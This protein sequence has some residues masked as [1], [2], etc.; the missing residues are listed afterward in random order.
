MRFAAHAD[1]AI[2]WL[3]RAN[4]VAR[5][6]LHAIALSLAS[7]RNDVL[8]FSRDKIYKS[9]NVFSNV[10]LLFQKIRPIALTVLQ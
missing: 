9:L 5:G 3:Q 1:E 7:V 6:L 10:P 2:P 4:F 8:S